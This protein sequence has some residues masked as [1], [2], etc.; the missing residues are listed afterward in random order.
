MK[1]SAFLL[2]LVVVGLLAVPTVVLG[3]EDPMFETEVPEDTL[4]PGETNELAVEFLNDADDLD[5]QVK[6]ATEVKATMKSGDTP[7]TVLSGTHRLG[8]LEDGR[9]VVDEFRVRVPQNVEAGTY[10]LPIELEYVY[11]GDESETT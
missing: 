7:F 10:R 2:V 8:T 4:V 6:P 11:D 5:D 1:R 3:A 9:P